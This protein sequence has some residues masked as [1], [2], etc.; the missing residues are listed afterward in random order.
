MSEKSETKLPKYIEDLG[1]DKY[2]VKCRHGEYI[3]EEKNAET[4]D[5]CKKLADNSNGKYTIDRLLIMRSIVEPKIDES[6]FFVSIKGSDYIKLQAAVNYI[7]G[8]DD[9]LQEEELVQKSSSK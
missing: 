8:I 2:R 1:E 7:Y 6:S 4:F 3:L 5:I 9:F